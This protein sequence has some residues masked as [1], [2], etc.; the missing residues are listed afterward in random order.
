MKK[1]ISLLLALCL[2]SACVLA[3]AADSK[4]A[5]GGTV[6]VNDPIVTEPETAEETTEEIAEEATETI[7]SLAPAAEEFVAKFQAIGEDQSILTPFAEATQEAARAL[8]ETA[9]GMNLIEASAISIDS[10]LYEGGPLTVT[11]DYDE[12]FTQFNNIL[13]I[14]SANENEFVAEPE[15]TEE[16]DLQL[17]LAEEVITN[18][19]NDAEACLAVLA[20]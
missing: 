9:D 18:I 20:D 4:T 10:E 7:V 15:V 5:G 8:C 17:E 11:L 19:L 12:D 13:V 6:V 16:G 2:L 1:I 3:L 14:I